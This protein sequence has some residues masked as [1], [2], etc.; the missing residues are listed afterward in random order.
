[1]K[2]SE[3]RIGNYVWNDYSGNMVVTGIREDEVFL[4]KDWG[5]TIGL[6]HENHIKGI[7]VDGK[8]LVQLGFETNSY[9][10][11][12]DDWYMGISYDPEFEDW[13]V[14][15]RRDNFH[16]KTIQYVHELQNIYFAITEKELKLKG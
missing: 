8:W 10:Y 13:H 4:T 16:V 6:Y 2:T 14:Y 11:K 7:H 3:L 15:E 9:E 1:M 5:L 12:I